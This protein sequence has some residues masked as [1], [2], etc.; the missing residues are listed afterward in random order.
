MVAEVVIAL[1]AVVLGAAAAAAVV[2]V[3]VVVMVA[4]AVAVV[5]VV[6]VVAEGQVEVT[7]INR[8]LVWTASFRAKVQMRAFSLPEWHGKERAGDC[9]IAMLCSCHRVLV[10]VR[11]VFDS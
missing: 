5:F 9:F 2:V 7:E 11:V 4:V 6:V 8:E 10:P 3:V 1:A